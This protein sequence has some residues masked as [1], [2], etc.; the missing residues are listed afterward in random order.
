MRNIHLTMLLTSALAMGGL[1]IG[2]ARADTGSA[3]AGKS[4]TL[5]GK[6]WCLGRAP[7]GKT[8]DVQLGASRPRVFKALGLS[9]CLD[10]APG[11]RCDVR[12]P[13]ARSP[14][15]EPQNKAD[16]ARRSRQ[17]G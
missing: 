11:V 8:C 14:Q 4:L 9:W 16:T 7:S 13:A 1:G 3:A 17:G 6:T 15:A 5:F 10:D 2:A 12:V